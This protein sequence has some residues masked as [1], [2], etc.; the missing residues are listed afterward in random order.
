MS[1]YIL[2]GILATVGVIA[3]E[4][5]LVKQPWWLSIVAG[6]VV[7]VLSVAYQWFM[8]RRRVK[9]LPTKTRRR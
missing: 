1:D 8:E 9:S 7:G 4:H 3:L 6:V 5:Y 2:L